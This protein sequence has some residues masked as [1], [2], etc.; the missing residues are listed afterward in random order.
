M[1]EHTKR[2]LTEC[3]K[4]S[5]N[6]KYTQPVHA[7]VESGVV[8]ILNIILELGVKNS[9]LDEHNWTAYM[10]ASQSRN[11][12]ALQQFVDIA[13]PLSSSVFPPARWASEHG[14]IQ[15]QGDAAELLYSG[16]GRA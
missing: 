16:K 15:L 4:A 9:C 1:L 5:L 14:S 8:D 3:D 13:H 10:T 11:E 6:D 7:A 12:F 2:L